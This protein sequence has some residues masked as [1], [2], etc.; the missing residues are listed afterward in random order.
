MLKARTLGVIGAVA[1]AALLQ[2]G[3]AS[4]QQAKCLAGKNKCE[5]KKGTGLIKCEQLA[6]TPGKPTDPNANDCVTKVDTKFTGGSDPTKGCFEKLENKSPNDCITFNDTAAAEGAIDSC[7]SAFVA[8]IDPPPTNQTK[9]GAGKKK[10]VSKL[11]A[12]IMKCNQLAE[13]PGKPTDPNAN[14]C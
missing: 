7:V 4:A 9:C 13:T 12:G 14:S 10:C 11:F 3:M 6:E 2:G 1:V 8:A 5:S